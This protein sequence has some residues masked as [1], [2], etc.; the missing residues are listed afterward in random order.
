MY[1]EI[2]KPT[3]NISKMINYNE[4]KVKAGSA[5]L[6]YAGNFL[7][8][9]ERL[10]FY[11]KLDRFN[12]LNQLNTRTKKNA[13]HIILNFHPTD[14]LDDDLLRTIGNDYMNRIGFGDQPYLL[15]RHSDT[16]LPHLHI[17]TNLIDANGDRIPTHNIGK[18][19]SEPARQAIEINYSLQKA[20]DHP[21]EKQFFLPV[22]QAQKLS[23][24]KS[25][26]KRGISNVLAN[27]VDTY[28]YSSLA[29][30]NAILQLCNVYADPCK[31]NS[32]VQRN[33]GLLY[34]MLDENGKKVGK[35][36]KASSIYFKPTLSYL[37]TK[38]QEG[39]VQKQQHSGRIKSLIDWHFQQSPGSGLSDLFGSLERNG[40]STVRRIS[41]DGRLYGITFVDHIKRTV[42]NGSSLG[43]SYSAAE[44]F[45]KAASG[46][47]QE[48][49]P[50]QPL[51]SITHEKDMG[52]RNNPITIPPQ[53]AN[54]AVLAPDNNTTLVE[55]LLQPEYTYREAETKRKKRRKRPSIND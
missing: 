51:P 12:S 43:K 34:R 2:G 45:K 8:E 18:R 13:Q 55:Q 14:K 49:Q 30:L 3:S 44:L 28:K 16:I 23:Y 9:K 48:L 54:S 10:N 27:V 36:I 26:T 38:F 46:S 7:Q 53:A 50:L 17:V 40:I 4:A 1:A 32:R 19:L 29:E 22:L 5:E 42:F 41:A 20:A 35:P 6:L 31:E 47:Y 25:Q 37:E 21:Q 52:K 24:G 15:Y 33:K 39:S 11:D